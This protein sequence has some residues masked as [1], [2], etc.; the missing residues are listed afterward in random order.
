MSSKLT[1][2]QHEKM[3]THFDEIEMKLDDGMIYFAANVI[4]Q[5]GDNYEIDG[6][7]EIQ[8]EDK[9]ATFEPFDSEEEL[10]PSLS[11]FREAEKAFLD[12]PANFIVY[13]DSQDVYSWCE[14]MKAESKMEQML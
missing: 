6:I 7:E 8:I 12:D 13:P 14:D 3:Q 10:S 4:F 11:Q 1:T 5:I 2:N 9:T